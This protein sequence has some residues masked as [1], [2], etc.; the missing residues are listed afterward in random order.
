MTHQGDVAG[1]TNS[2]TW[3]ARG[4]AARG[5][6]VRVA[7]RPES[8]LSRRFAD[9]PV[10]AVPMR[11]PRGARLAGETRRWKSWI[12]AEGIDVVNAHAS[13]DRHLVSMLRIAGCRAALV[14]TRRNRARSSGGRFRAWYDAA[15]TD[16]IIAVSQQVADEFLRR[17][18]PRAKIH[19]IR[20]GLP[21][22]EIP[23]ADPDRVARLRTELGLEPGV[24][25]IGVVARRKS[26]ED[27][28]R[29]AALLGRPL[30]ILFVGIDEDPA[31]VALSR[32]LPV[33]A[34]SLCLGFRDDVADLA[35]L[36]DVFVLPSEIE[37]FSLALL[38][39]MA[40]ALPCVATDAGGNREALENGA[41]VVVPPRDAQA[42]ARAI[43]A[44]L[45]DP[46][47]AR[48]MGERAFARVHAEFSVERTIER[49]EALYASLL[50]EKR[51]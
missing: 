15:S 40:R 43:A 42:L 51:A 30:T 7:C 20:N 34:R 26:Q 27:L 16:A 10:R 45:D 12:E 24:P 28:L 1:S 38:E 50:G 32:N 8:L 11:L 37:G 2:I 47:E 5:H 9:G 23:R 17:G 41:G 29:A 22:G 49:T 31:L 39:A 13:L 18:T 48:R 21:L 44:L 46:A 33:G 6:D 35:A 3:L 19:V 4:L 25:V 14:H 36:F